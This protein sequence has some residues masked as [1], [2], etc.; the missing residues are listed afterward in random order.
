MKVLAWGMFFREKGL[1]RLFQPTHYQNVKNLYHRTNTL[2]EVFAVAIHVFNQFRLRE[3]VSAKKV[4][5]VDTVDRGTER[6]GCFWMS[7][8]AGKQCAGQSIIGQQEYYHAPSVN[9]IS[10]C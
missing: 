7:K 6:A 10:L 9:I 5:E 2:A 3:A 1:C 4:D 8:P